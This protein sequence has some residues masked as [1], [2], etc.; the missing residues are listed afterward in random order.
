MLVEMAPIE[1]AAFPSALESGRL[2][3]QRA[4][5]LQQRAAQRVAEMGVP[6]DTVTLSEQ[7]AGGLSLE[8]YSVDIHDSLIDAEVAQYLAL[9]STKVI[10]TTVEMNQA[11]MA[12]L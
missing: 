8:S 10:R 9:A 6:I 1:Q 5:D 2:G 11:G 7:A 3:I 4:V 12:F